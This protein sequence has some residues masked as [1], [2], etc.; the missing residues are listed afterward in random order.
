MDFKNLTQDEMNLLFN[1]YLDSKDAKSRRIFDL[2]FYTICT[3]VSSF[4][5]FGVFSCYNPLLLDF[6][7]TEFYPIAFILFLVLISSCYIV[8]T[9]IIRI[10]RAINRRIG[11]KEFKEALIFE[12]VG[13]TIKVKYSDDSFD[14][15]K[16]YAYR[17]KDYKIGDLVIVARYKKLHFIF[18]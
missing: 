10:I 3:L 8:V 2:I 4:I 5:I 17:F 7:H 18:K 6:G 9:S 12:L 16:D 14:T 15:I 1:G 13:K 11:L